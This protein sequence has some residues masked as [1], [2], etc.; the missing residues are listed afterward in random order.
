MWYNPGM[1]VVSVTAAAQMLGLSRARIY[2]LIYE[3]KL[4]CRISGKTRLVPVESL[5]RYQRQRAERNTA[6]V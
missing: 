2:Q 4:D 1:N 3:R 6:A 5:R